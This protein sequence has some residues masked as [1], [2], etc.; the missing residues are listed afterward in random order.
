MYENLVDLCLCQKHVEN[1]VATEQNSRT[2]LALIYQEK[3]IVIQ[4][5]VANKKKNIY[6]I[7]MKL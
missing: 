5:L 3:I 4:F 6:I 2:Q 1:A 7:D